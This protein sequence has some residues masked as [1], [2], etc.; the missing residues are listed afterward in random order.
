MLSLIDIHNARSNQYVGHNDINDSDIGIMDES[1]GVLQ[2]GPDLVKVRWSQ[3]GCA[4]LPT[5]ADTKWTPF[6]RRYFQVHFPER[7]C[8]NSD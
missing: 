5:E 6:L 2:N 1:E 8:Q 3:G 4:L 7:K